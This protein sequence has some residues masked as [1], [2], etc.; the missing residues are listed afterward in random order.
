MANILF[1]NNIHTHVI[2]KDYDI[3]TIGCLDLGIPGLD[4]L[5]YDCIRASSIIVEGPPGSGKTIFAMQFIHEGLKK[6]EE[7]LYINF[8]ENLSE[9]IYKAETLGINLKKY[10]DLGSLYYLHEYIFTEKNNL[11]FFIDTILALIMNK[12]IKRIVI[13]NIDA[14]TAALTRDEYRIF[15]Q[16]I[17][18]RIKSL[19][20]V[21]MILKET[22]SNNTKGYPYLEEYLADIVISLEEDVIGD[23]IRRYLVIKKSKFTNY[24]PMS[25]E[26]EIK[27][28]GLRLIM[29]D[30]YN[31]AGSYSKEL[32]KTGIKELDI[33]LE[34]G[35]PSNSITVIKGPS[36]TMKSIIALYIALYNAKFHN[37]NILYVSY[38]ES[39]DQILNTIERLGYNINSIK[40]RI[41]IVSISPIHV[42]PTVINRIMFRTQ[43]VKKFDIRID[44][45]FEMV[46]EY[47]KPYR[48]RNLLLATLS[49]AKREGLTRII[50]LNQS[51]PWYIDEYGLDS[52]ADV[53]IT[54]RFKE[55]GE[56]IKRQL[57]VIKSRAV[58]IK[59]TRF[60][61]IINDPKG[62]ISIKL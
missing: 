60:Y 18:Q 12:K 40:N 5:F 33:L 59:L 31:M 7:V 8:F 37:K 3:I 26:Y 41:K 16:Q 9:F 1:K 49:L 34:G 51:R 42:N 25:V 53:V 62:N 45:G 4:Q 17:I 46:L 29:H 44:D 36:G 30:I 19:N 61:D 39:I 14:L 43:P 10:V 55:E 48:R 27:Y 28:G 22:S 38:K 47:I 13:D 52:I 15:L 54:T 50:I 6:G 21:L 32:I 56:N 35:I 58:N 20:A 11:L 2:A 23:C 24:I 57:A